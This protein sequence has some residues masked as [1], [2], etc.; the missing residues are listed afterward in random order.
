MEN[1]AEETTNLVK[2][3]RKVVLVTGSAKGIGRA[4]I[5]E[6]AQAGYDC[7]IN[8]HT[9]RKEAL[10]LQE[11]IKTKYHVRSLAIKAD[12]SKEAEVDQMFTQIEKELGSVDIVVNNAA[13]DLSDLF[14][15][16]TV[17]NYQKTLEVNVIGAFIVSRRASR[18]M[19]DKKWGRIINISSTNGMNTY[20]PV[21]LAYDSSKAALN[22][23]T[24]N[25]AIEFAPYV[26]VNAIAPGFIGTEAELKDYDEEFLKSEV[27]KI[28]LNRYGEPS[29]VAKLVRFLISDD[30]NYINNSIIRIDGGQMNS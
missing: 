12:V 26:T 10:F 29:E 15:L 13:V 18:K 20:Y 27:S 17:E 6:L 14:E 4:I 16:Q 30:A 1:I 9:S 23:L 25:L 2:Q 28:L 11:E 5:L 7:V 19:F 22:S 3:T 24:H 21:C 8:Y